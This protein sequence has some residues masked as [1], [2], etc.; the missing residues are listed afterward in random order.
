MIWGAV[1]LLWEVRPFWVDEWRI[2]YNLKFKSE[3]E[4]WGKLAF[5]QQFP[6]LYLSL[7]KLFTAKLHYSYFSLRLPS[8]LIGTAA[9]WGVYR[10]A[11]KVYEPNN[12]N[13]CN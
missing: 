3:E 13:D 4:L 10:L 6:R 12:Y 9:M 5:M 11:G 1:T 2:I 8:F 7:L